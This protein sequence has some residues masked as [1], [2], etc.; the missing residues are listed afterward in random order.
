MM[1]VANISTALAA[2]RRSRPPCL[3]LTGLSGAGK[4]TLAS[5]LE[6]RLIQIGLAAYAL[7]GDELRTGLNQDLDYTDAHRTENVRRVAE[8]ARLMVNAGVT[9]IVALISPFQADRA[10]ARARFAPDEFYEIFVDAPLQV[11]ER[12]DPKGLYAKARR[13]ELARLTGIDSPYEPPS[14]PDLH[15]HTDAD[16]AHQCVER[17]IQLLRV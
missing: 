16:D 4:S 14:Q 15:L 17:I 5:L 9:P 11:C 12:R 2:Q 10:L 7:D 1:S 6:Q 13:G 8:V 3:W